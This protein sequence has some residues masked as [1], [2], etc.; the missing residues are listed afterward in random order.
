MAG[1]KVLLRRD[2]FRVTAPA[3]AAAALG[4]LSASEPDKAAGSERSP[5]PKGVDSAGPDFPPGSSVNIAEF[6]ARPGL[7]E[8]CTAAIQRAIDLC[9]S[10]GGGTVTVPAGIFTT[11]TLRLRSHVCLQ[12]GPGAVLLGSTVLADYPIQPT[13]AYRSLHDSRG[14]RALIYADE[15][16]N[17]AVFGQGTIDGRGEKFA[18]AGSDL[19]GRPRL[20]QFVS[21]RGVRVEG[22]R[23]RNSALWMQH[24]LNCERVCIRGLDVWNHANHNNDMLDIDGCRQVTVSDCI[25]DTDDDGIT[26]KSTGVAPCENIAITN[27][28]VSSRCNAFKC[29]TESTGGFRNIVISNCV[30]KPSASALGISGEVAGISGIA[31]EVVDGGVLEGVL[32]SN[33]VIEGTRAPLFIRLGNRG[34]LHRKDAP[35]PPVGCLR[36]VQIQN[37]H[38]RGAGDIG[39]SITGLPGH[40]VENVRL[41][42]VTID[43]GQVGEV[44]Q[45]GA[46]DER[47]KSYPEATMWGPLP[48]YGFYVRHAARIRFRDVTVRPASGESR[49]SMVVEDVD[50]SPDLRCEELTSAD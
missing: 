37:L 1:S 44:R 29:G 4:R 42:D 40:R 23:L 5:G 19:D 12:L 9:H 15:A 31:L 6:G 49:P 38:V 13:P 35:T 16:E 32:I 26:L 3:V 25:G 21:C 46:V 28:I 39:C 20:I 33:V 24:Y 14:F 43:F 22:L 17:I 2:F 36:D 8:V 41:R 10:R 11:G 48:A 27:C 30:V 45:T 18:F 50:G 47:E 34:R 7:G